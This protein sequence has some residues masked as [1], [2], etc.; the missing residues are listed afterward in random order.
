M[1]DFLFISYSKGKGA[2]DSFKLVAKKKTISKHS[3]VTK[4]SKENKSNKNKASSKKTLTKRKSVSKANPKDRNAI[5]KIS[6]FKDSKQSL[7]KEEK[8]CYLKS[9]K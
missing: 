9:L 1:F 5:T 6:Y 4:S 8:N 3:L 7:T 2:S